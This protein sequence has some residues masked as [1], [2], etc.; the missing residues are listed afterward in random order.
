MSVGRRVGMS[1]SPE[2]LGK[3]VDLGVTAVN[4][5]LQRA[6]WRR[7]GAGGRSWRRGVAC[8]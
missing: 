6:E 7:R 2:R 1:V 5:E 3:C 4:N 8:R